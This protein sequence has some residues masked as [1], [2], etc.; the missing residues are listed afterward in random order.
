MALFSS[1]LIV[2][3]M[4]ILSG[5][6]LGGLLYH[7]M[8]KP[9][10]K[11]ELLR[12]RDSRGKPLKVVMETDIG[13]VCRKTGGVIHRFIKKGRGWTFNEMGRMTTKFFGIE[14]SAYTSL[15][16]DGPITTKTSLIDH[17]K[18]LWG[19]QFGK[20][21]NALPDAQRQAIETD[22][23]G[24]TVE[25]MKVDAEKEGLPTLTSDDIYD[26]DDNVMLRRF[27][28]STTKKKFGESIMGDVFKVLVGA[29]MMYFLIQRGI[30]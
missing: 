23:I 18:V 12:P 1:G 3:L 15:I 26:E 21:Y 2:P 5:T 6:I 10:K 19:D 13:L 14:G 16:E 25:L 27:A 20:I 28:Q 8:R 22:V 30:V 9:T 29:L 11:V 17:L 24:V 4:F 7:N